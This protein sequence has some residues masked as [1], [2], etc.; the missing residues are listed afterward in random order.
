MARDPHSEKA[1]SM[2]RQLAQREHA[3]HEPA[4]LDENDPNRVS[5]SFVPGSPRGIPRRSAANSSTLMPVSASS[6]R[7]ASRIGSARLDGATRPGSEFF[8]TLT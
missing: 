2:L 3:A 6:F 5:E 8:E 7:T 1:R 4:T